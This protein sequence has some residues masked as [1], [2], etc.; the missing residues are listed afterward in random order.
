[1]GQA[2]QDDTANAHSGPG[3]PGLTEEDIQEQPDRFKLLLL[4]MVDDVH[5]NPGPATIPVPYVLQ[6]HQ[7]S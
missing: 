6:R 7:P 4:L 5:P 2:S 3:Q 1:M